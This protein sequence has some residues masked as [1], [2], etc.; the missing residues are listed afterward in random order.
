LQEIEA[1]LGDFG[2]HLMRQTNRGMWLEC[3]ESS[4]RFA[5]LRLIRQEIGRQQMASFKRVF[6]L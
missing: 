3:P 6:P 1:W 4:R 5:L 2:M